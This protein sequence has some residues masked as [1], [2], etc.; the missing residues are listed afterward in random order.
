MQRYAQRQAPSVAN[1]KRLFGT[2]S[3]FEMHIRSM[4]E[5][6]LEQIASRNVDNLLHDQVR[7]VLRDM[8]TPEIALDGIRRIARRA[9]TLI[10][11]AELPPDKT[12]P[13]EWVE[14]WERAEVNYPHDD[15][16]LPDG[17]GAQCSLLR[18]VTGMGNTR[19]PLGK[20]VTKTTCLLVDHLHSVG[21]FGQHREEFPRNKH[22]DRLRGIE[23]PVGDLA[24]R[25]SD[26]GSAPAGG[27]RLRYD[28]IGETTPH[29]SFYTGMIA[30]IAVPSDGIAAFC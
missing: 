16:K 23:R 30:R 1:L 2:A 6:R 7:R 14:H 19:P 15:G 22:L 12:L 20:C 9:L 26:G 17:Y 25:E 29:H 24:G 21:N 13:A 10:W 27:H 5:L 28:L 18:L 11:D 3:G 8:D 4:L